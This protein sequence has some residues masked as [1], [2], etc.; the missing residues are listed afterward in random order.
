[1]PFEHTQLQ[2]CKVWKETRRQMDLELLACPSLAIKS[3]SPKF[4]VLRRRHFWL[5]CENT[6]PSINGILNTHTVHYR[7]EQEQ[8]LQG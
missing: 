2:L 3:K 7:N 4:A 8:A 5:Y 6:F 1:M